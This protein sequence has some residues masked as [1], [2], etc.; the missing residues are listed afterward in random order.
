MFSQVLLNHADFVVEQISSFESAEDDAEDEDAVNLM[1]TKCI[2]KLINYAG[3]KHKYRHGVQD[4][5]KEQQ[6]QKPAKKPVRKPG[7]A[8]TKSTK[9]R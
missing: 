4:K 2:R 9:S 3:L 7:S 6:K 5:A 8:R 1:S